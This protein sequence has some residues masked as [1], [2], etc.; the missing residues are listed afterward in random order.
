MALGLSDNVEE[1]VEMT[2]IPGHTTDKPSEPCIVDIIPDDYVCVLV[3]DQYFRIEDGHVIAV[4]PLEQ[5][6]A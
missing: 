4:I 3:D 5:K 2:H 1:T 6:T